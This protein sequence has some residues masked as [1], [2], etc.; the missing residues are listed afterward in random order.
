M[1][2]ISIKA[3]RGVNY[4]ITVSDSFDLLTSKIKD[5]NTECNKICIITDNSVKS[6]YGEVIMNSLLDICSDILFYIPEIQY[7]SDVE[8]LINEACLFL[9]KNSFVEKDVVVSLAGGVVTDFAAM[10]AA[11][12]L[13]GIEL[14]NIPTSVTAMVDTAIDG[15]TG[16][17]LGNIYNV[18]PVIKFPKL[19]YI[20][21]ACIQSLDA[22]A[23]YGGFA[24]VMRTAI[25][26]S[27]SVYEWLID[28]LYEIS[29]RDPQIV[30]D[31][32]E[33]SIMFRKIYIEKDPQYI[34]GDLM[35]MDLGS[36]VGY[37]LYKLKHNELNLGE[38]ITLGI[39]AAAHISMKREMLSLE[40]YLEIRDMF[41]PF[42]LPISVE[43]IDIDELINLT[44]EDIK[45]DANGKCYVLLKKIGKAV[46]D[47]TVSDEELKEALAE[48]R[49][50]D[51]DYVVE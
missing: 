19:V 47:R 48:I 34:K 39:I 15:K 35:L 21:T 12:Y 49:F 51:D 32:I 46:I 3:P 42:N 6:L 25:V 26:K 28:K 44:H 50:S 5:T 22:R 38:C 37:S 45:K 1:P 16:Y 18:T 9:E 40:E 43:N 14:I 31:M 13:E 27:S 23:Y 41:V 29:D 4:N 2:D 24:Y 7:E 11:R 30:S 10:V 36:T 33:Q 17:L 20:N 8:K